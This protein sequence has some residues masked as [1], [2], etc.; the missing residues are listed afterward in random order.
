MCQKLAEQTKAAGG[1]AYAFPAKISGADQ[2]TRS[3]LIGLLAMRPKK[4]DNLELSLA[5][6][7]GMRVM[8]TKNLSVTLGAA[9]GARGTV[10]G[11][12]WKRAC[13]QPPSYTSDSTSAFVDPTTRDQIPEAILVKLDQPNFGSLGPLPPGVFAIPSRVVSVSQKRTS[14]AELKGTIEQFPLVPA[15]AFT[16]WKTQVRT[17]LHLA[18]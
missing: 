4:A 10:V 1:V 2:K 11:F 7:V 18:T 13:Q 12:L 5:C 16:V 8:I 15:Y 6:F 9:N 3:D 14:G 17:L